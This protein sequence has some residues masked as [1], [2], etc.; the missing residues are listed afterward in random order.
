MRARAR[1]PCEPVEYGADL[2]RLE[3]EAQASRAVGHVCEYAAREF[4]APLRGSL[5]GVK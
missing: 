5:A 4:D 3:R 1:E 2:V